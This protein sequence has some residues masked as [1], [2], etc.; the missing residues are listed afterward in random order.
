MPSIRKTKTASGAIAVQAVVYENRKTVV[1][2]HFGSAKTKKE[3]GSLIQDAEQWFRARDG[4]SSLFTLASDERI[5]RLGVNRC[6][7]G[8]YDIFVRM[9]SGTQNPGHIFSH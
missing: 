5:L 6:A 9:L 1:L 3:L 7:A 4:Q 8:A 2:K